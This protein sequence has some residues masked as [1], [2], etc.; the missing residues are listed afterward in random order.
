M[1]ST[2]VFRLEKHLRQYLCSVGDYLADRLGDM[3]ANPL[4]LDSIHL[5]LHDLVCPEN[6]Q[7]PNVYTNEA[8][9]AYSSAYLREVARSLE[10]ASHIVAEIQGECGGEDIVLLADRA[11]NM[12]SKSLVLLMKPTTERDFE[13]F[14]ELYRRFDAV[15]PLPYPLTPHVTLAYF[16]PGT[17][18]VNLLAVLALERKAVVAVEMTGNRKLLTRK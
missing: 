13:R 8:K 9:N 18:D 17:I 1:G 7:T 11:V 3:L 12:V 14:L 10:Q 2:V 6:A 4:P 16:R 15:T 5:T